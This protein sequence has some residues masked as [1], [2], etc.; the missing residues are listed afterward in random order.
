[1]LGISWGIVT[2]VILLAYGN[3]MHSALEVG[4]RGA[5]GD[6]VVVMYGGQ[7]SMQAGGERAGRPVRL[8]MEDVELIR[9]QSLIKSA[10]PEYIRSLPITFGTRQ[11]SAAVRGVAPEYGRMRCE[12][13]GSGKGRFL[14]SEDVAK[15]NRVVFLGREVHRKLFGSL[16]AVGESIRIGGISFA[17]IGIMDDKVQMSSYYMPDMYS[18]FIPY[19]TVGDLWDSRYLYTLVFQSVNPARQS[20]ALE[21]VRQALG[22]RHR[23]NPSDKRALVMNDSVEITAMIGGITGGLKFVL[24]FIGI[25]TLGIGGVGVMNIMFVSVRERTREIGVRKALGARRRDIL[26]Q[27][28]AEGIATTFIGGMAGIMISAAIITLTGPIPFLSDFI[29]DPLR[30]SDIHLILSAQ[31]MALATGIL[32][33]VGLTSSLLPA[34]RAARLDPIESLR[35]E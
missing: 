32:M 9:E 10:S 24:A 16:P 17:V 33:F 19:T 1:M 25:L 28:L 13:P 29:G 14:D 30:A 35:Y 6:G 23:F 5:F 11:T 15:R 31:I 7:T 3:G 18:V 20:Q 2:V 4:F 12:R 34:I 21:Q 22:R 27:F 8:E 26:L